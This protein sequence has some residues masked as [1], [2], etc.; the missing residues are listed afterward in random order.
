MNSQ[1]DY[2]NNLGIIEQ[3]LGSMAA[4]DFSWDLEINDPDDQIMAIAQGLNW[5]NEELRASV[6]ERTVYMEKAGQLE[7]ILS[8][9]SDY[10]TALDASSIVAITD[11]KG[12]I[13]YANEKFC[14]ISGYERHELIGQNQS[15][16]NSGFHSKE[17]WRNMWATIGAGDVWHEEVCN[18]AKDGS[19]YWVDTAIVPFLDE[20]EKP[21]Q[22]LAIRKDVTQQ[23]NLEESLINSIIFDEEKQREGVAF[24]LHE[25]IAQTLAVLNFQM[26]LIESK[27]KGKGDDEL[28][29]AIDTI[30]KY[31]NESIN[32]TRQLATDLMPR[33]M[34]NYGLQ[35]SMEDFIMK[36]SDKLGF[37]IDFVADTNA[38]DIEKELE[39]TLYRAFTGL[40]EYL[41]GDDDVSN[42][43]LKIDT[44]PE[45]K[46]SADIKRTG[47]NGFSPNLNVGEA[48]KLEQIQKRIELKGG[49]MKYNYNDLRYLN[50][51]EIRFAGTSQQ[52]G[53]TLNVLQ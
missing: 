44:V 46:A 29:T 3:M 49:Q 28:D 47:L 25:G 51:V 5:L 19:T 8:E 53:E 22:Y 18:R 37:S 17:F 31:I 41:G 11:P 10:K 12:T 45:L 26:Q 35:D 1:D 14:Q 2:S 32:N 20:N 30:K 24:D 43:L 39:I 4:L 38:K 34:M 6:V 16:V 33:A 21:Y 27:V 9:V 48:G 42:V 36:S 7:R 50:S 15:I 23:K 40:L 52:T 13:L